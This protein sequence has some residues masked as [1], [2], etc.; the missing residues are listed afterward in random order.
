MLK[1]YRLLIPLLFLPLSAMAQQTPVVE[2]FGG[3]SHLVANVSASS[4]NLNGVDASVTEN[5]NRWFGGKLEYNAQFG[6]EAGN[7]VNTETLMY[8]PVF[9]YRKNPKFVP[10]GEAL[11][12]AV[13]G[14]P[15]YLDVSERVFHFAAAVGGG[16]DVTLTDRVALRVIQADYLLTRFSGTRQDNFRLSAGI[17]LRFGRK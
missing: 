13:R 16:L 9:S 2:V 7:K 5:L 6:T 15:E 4:F 10:F 12:G 3:Y 17:L 11:A 14:G 8:G 1:G